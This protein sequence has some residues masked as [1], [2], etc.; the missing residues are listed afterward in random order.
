MP[1]RKDINNDL[2]E[3]TAAAH[4]SGEG[5]KACLL[6]REHSSKF[7]ACLRS[8][9]CN[10]SKIRK[11]LTKYNFVE[12]NVITKPLSSKQNSLGFYKKNIL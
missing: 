11:T 8:S 10:D 1:S 2:R 4:Q 9:K 5:Y 7:N 12:T 6:S 3:A